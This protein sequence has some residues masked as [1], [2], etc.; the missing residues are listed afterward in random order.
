MYRPRDDVIEGVGQLQGA[1]FKGK[2][3]GLGL[4]LEFEGGELHAAESPR[5]PVPAVRDDLDSEDR[6]GAEVGLEVGEEVR[7][8]DRLGNV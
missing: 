4:R 1:G 8:C 2:R 5:F 6:A 7:G 3:Q